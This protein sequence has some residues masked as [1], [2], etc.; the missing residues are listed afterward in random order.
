MNGHL[1]VEQMDLC[2]GDPKGVDII[3]NPSMMIAVKHVAQLRHATVKA[4][5]KMLK[6]DIVHVILVEVMQKTIVER[7]AALVI[8]ANLAKD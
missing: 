2:A 1:R 4:N 6:R 8:P 5:R 3:P 7:I